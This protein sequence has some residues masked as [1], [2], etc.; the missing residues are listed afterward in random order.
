M[1]EILVRTHLLNAQNE[2]SAA[3][4]LIDTGPETVI[5]PGDNLL[6]ILAQAEPGAVFSIDPQFVADLSF[7]DLPKPVTLKNLIDPGPSRVDTNLNGPLLKGILQTTQ[8]NTVLSGLRLEGHTKDGTLISPG[9]QNVLDR[10]LLMGSVDGQHRG[11]AANNADIRVSRCHV[12]NI[13]HS[14]DTQAVAGF[15]KTRNLLV[16]DS[17]LEA[18]GENIIFGGDD[19]ESESAIPQ[20]ITITD[21]HLYKPPHWKDTPGLTVKNLYEL[22]NCLR[23]VMKRCHLENNWV[24]GQDGF[25]IV[26]T[27]RNQ[28]GGNPYA[29]IEDCLIEDCIVTRSPAGVSILGRDY[30]NV[31]K[32]MRNM[33]LRKVRFEEINDTYSGNGRQMMISGGPKDFI[34]DQ[35][36]WNTVTNPHSAIVFDQEENKLEGFQYTGNY[37]HEGDYG[38]HGTSAPGLGVK[39]L[40]FYCPQGYTWERNTI[41]DYAPYIVWPAGTELVPL[42]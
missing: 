35:C 16:E 33:V 7:Y 42:P 22:K 17:F 37:A 24:N 21:C 40:D 32:I 15:N 10:C 29:T 13:W 6:D 14:Q 2:I 41:V 39:A 12:G 38:I 18:S 1:D 25:A 26:L 3:L 11:V 31:S 9:S 20:D 27:V 34:V 36:R 4:K 5:R 23:V 19:C 28:D 8:P 30:R